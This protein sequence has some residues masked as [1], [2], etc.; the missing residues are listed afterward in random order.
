MTASFIEIL[1]QILFWLA[2]VALG[3]TYVLYPFL[4]AKCIPQV[5]NRKVYA[6]EQDEWPH[7]Y[8]VMAMYNEAAV[9]KETMESIVAC[10]YPQDKLHVR[11]G[12][13]NSNDGSDDM[14][15]GFD[16]HLEDLN[17]QV[18]EGRCGKIHI[19]NSLVKQLPSD[20]DAVLILCDANVTWTKDVLRR[21]ASHFREP[22][23]GVVASCVLD[24]KENTEGI[25]AQEEAYVN[26]ENLVKFAEG[27]RWGRMMGAFGA[28]YAMRLCLY[29]E[30]PQVFNV[31]DFYQ[32]M[33]CYEKGYQ[34]LV[35]LKAICHE[36]VSEDI[37][38]EFRRK[39]RI[40]KGNFQNLRRFAHLYLPWN[41]GWATCFAF[42]S[43]KGLRWFG[44]LLLLLLFACTALLATQGIFLYQLA[45]IAILLSF[46]C[47][48][49]D[50]LLGD[51]F[52]FKPFRFLR[53][54][55][56]MNVALLRGG[57]EFCKGVQDSVWEPTRRVEKQTQ[58][59]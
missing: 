59:G 17:L 24:E 40:S 26:I 10:E 29:E 12:S 1:L 49:M 7:V 45:G 43:H 50:K 37:S 16:S 42:W 47:A 21:L 46:A 5:R 33:V 31:D 39:Q 13:D 58:T 2:I 44:P 4:M 22:S 56:T 34:G 6:D 36:A 14:V 53:Y 11:I 27:E 20:E 25:A 32:T 38:E 54:F 52:A 9:I 51:K 23:V 35:D 3:H 18:F 19:V 28:C 15:L 48:W 41:G 57:I 8:V 30:I 55:Y